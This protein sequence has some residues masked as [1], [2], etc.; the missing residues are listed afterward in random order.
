MVVNEITSNKS[1]WVKTM[2]QEEYGLPLLIRTPLKSACYT[3]LAFL[4]FGLIP[5]ISLCV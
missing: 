3:F 1:L 5:P 4:I 2:L